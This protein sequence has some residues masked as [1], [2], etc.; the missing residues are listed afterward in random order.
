MTETYRHK[1]LRKQLVASLRQRGISNES[2]LKVIG[3][4][5]R[6][7]FLDK[8]FEEWAYQD[9]AFPIGNKQTISQP[10]TVAYQ[11]DLL[12]VKKREK[13]M[14]IG[15]GSGYQAAVLASLG[16]RVFS[17][18]RQE[19]LYKKAKDFLPKLG[20]P[21]IR[22]FFKDGYKGL[23]EFAPFD[24]ILVTAGAKQVPE[25]LKQQLKIKGFLVIPV[26]DDQ[27]QQMLRIT[28]LSETDFMEEA[29]DLFAFVPFK[30]GV[31]KS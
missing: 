31:A 12:E 27:K 24:K 7:Y 19:S 22:L 6:H 17:I 26:G 5:P 25:S 28:R 8:A 2:I 9:K 11:T 4:I 3:S 16:A 30:S 23:P 21:S 29:F 10:Y 13:V 20:F 15:T 1:G 14:E 18:E